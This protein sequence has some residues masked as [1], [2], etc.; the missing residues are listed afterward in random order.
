MSLDLLVELG[1]EE[2]PAG[3]LAK[4]MVALE[5]RAQEKLGETRFRFESV[6]C[7]GTP[8]RLTLLIAGLA[9][10]QQDLEEEM[11]GPPAGVAFDA[12]GKPTRAAEG[13][14][15]RNGVA[16]S[17]LRKGPAEGK[18]GEYLLCTRRESGKSA[19]N[20]LPDI[21]LELLGN[22]PWP[23]SMR[24]HE[25]EEVFVRP[26]HWL[27][28]ILGGKLLPF[29]FAGIDAGMCTRGHRFLAPAAIELTGSSQQYV[30]ALRKAFVIVDPET[31]RTLI[32]A[33]IGR[34]EVEAGA[35]VRPDPELIDEVANLVEYPVGIC[36]EFPAEYLE[37]P[38]QVIVSAM[39]SHQRYFAMNRS[40]GSLLNRFVT[41]AGTVTRDAEVVRKGNQRVIAARLADAQF[42]FREDQKHDLD[43]FASKLQQV[44]FQ[45]K[46]GTIADKVARLSAGAV[47]LAND[48]GMN[49]TLVTRA[50][51]LCKAD[52][53]CQMVSEF[54]ELQ[55]TMGRRYATLA[56]EPAEVCAA[57]EEHY[58]P[59][60]A[61]DDLPTSDLGA[62][63]GAADRLDTIVGCFSI[64]VV[65]TGSADPF[66]L[67]RAALG[68]LRLFVDR[69]WSVDLELL[70]ARAISE[71]ARQ[72]G[73]QVDH[74]RVQVE[75][76]DFLR[77][78]FRGL[79]TDGQ[80]LPG[81]CV[82]AALSIGFRNPRDAR[83]RA[84]AVSLLRGRDD[85]EPLAAAFKRVAN[86]LKGQSTSALPNP[87]AFVEDNE[88]S[89]WSAFE[90]VRERVDSSL[91]KQD[92]SLALTILSELKGPVDLFFDAVLV[93]D[94][95]E[96]V[97]T[98]RLAMLG[99]IN[100]TFTRIADFRQLA[101]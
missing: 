54:P 95:D 96:A 77:V 18:K 14:A 45:K 37:V 69:E 64:G 58:L 94:K 83:A 1:T 38:E 31:R 28:S 10:R 52:L 19:A 50:A 97:R 11:V 41:I 60:G 39:R 49:E 99:K 6:R 76:L 92:Y 9:D 24:W 75:V 73:I 88:R 22:L 57:I 87:A 15:K 98:N 100:D 85:F 80:S 53:T 84:V 16:L 42:F 23:K 17:E 5:E 51:Q 59:R 32:A 63:V 68:V 29:A 61:S 89:L 12:E 20:L 86:I 66:G 67:R 90:G 21:L 93:M 35:T 40:D 81:D 25:R 26:V 55:G 78:R 33:E 47:A 56:G 4:A 36:G 43:Y 72:Q 7:L 44:V 91:A 48:L 2:I 74:A 34:L 70:V 3:Y 30:Q 27:V 46:L 79:L 101:V 65:P 71:V 82:D 62:V 13:F 8:R